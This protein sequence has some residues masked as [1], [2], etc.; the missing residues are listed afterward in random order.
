[1]KYLKEDYDKKTMEEQFNESYEI[2]CKTNEPFHIKMNKIYEYKNMNKQKFVN[3][4]GLHESFYSKFISKRYIP[5]M[6]TFMSMC[7]GFNLDLPAAESLLAS[8]SL[9]FKKTNKLDCAYMFLLTHYQG[10]CI[11]DCNKILQDLGF[12]EAKELLGSFGIEENHY[13]KKE[14]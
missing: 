2:M 3:R 13:H 14:K 12:N 6:K 4:T 1:M 11:E 10:L 9:D 5:T 8:L 7:M